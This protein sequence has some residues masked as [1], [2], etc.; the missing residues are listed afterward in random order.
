MLHSF[1]IPH[2]H[3]VQH[4]TYFERKVERES[5]VLFYIQKNVLFSYR[6]CCK[7]YCVKYLCYAKRM[8]DFRKSLHQMLREMLR[9]FDQRFTLCS[10]E[11]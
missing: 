10:S 11:A 9:S 4:F 2:K 8:Q 7:Q 1:D 6:E 5:N 3:C